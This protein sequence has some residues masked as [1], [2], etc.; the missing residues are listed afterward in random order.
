MPETGNA[1]R[2]ALIMPAYNAAD[3]IAGAV[4]SVLSQSCRDIELIV[5]DD[6]SGD[7]T[8]QIL[9]ELAAQDGRLR[10]IRAENGGPARARN[11]GL[12]AVRPGTDYIMFVDADDVLEPDAVAYALEKS[13]GAEL[14]LMGFA[15]LRED[16]GESLYAERE[17]RLGPAELGEA[18]P[19][20]YKANLLN[21]VWGK[22]YKA[23]LLT[24]EAGVRFADY[25]WGEDRLFIF[26]CLE[27]V[28]T[29]Q[30]L[31]AC[32][33]RYVMHRGESLITRY[34]DKKFQVCLLADRRAEALAERFGSEDQ[35]WLRAMFAKS[36]FSCLTNLFS[37]SCGLSSREKRDAVRE[38][39]TNE[40]VRRRCRDAAG[41]LPVRFLCAVLRSGSV[42]LNLL[43]FRLVAWV[44]RAAPQL[45]IRLK[46]RK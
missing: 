12:E 24:G 17:Q 18:F 31:P 10:P 22:L 16:G 27:R 34:Y 9:A 26:D 36:V 29:V 30:V 38:I 41:G 23:E 14:V 44:G 6:G 11:R 21:Q 39:V 13:A 25:R 4:R 32:K 45:F 7:G 43:C 5:V 33:Y 8:G 28:K 3:S 1:P 15:I 19:R 46:H 20:L 42:G 35:A 37:P 40:Q 2:V